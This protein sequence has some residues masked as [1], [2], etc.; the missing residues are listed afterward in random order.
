MAAECGDLASH[1]R[2]SRASHGEGRSIQGGNTLHGECG[3]SWKA[4]PAPGY[5]AVGVYR[6]GSFHRLMT[7][8]SIPTISGE[9]WG[10]LEKGRDFQELGCTS[11][12]FF[13]FFMVLSQ[14]CHS[15]GGCVI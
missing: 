1:R 7:G 14:N 3:P 6:G 8:R 10:F 4:S 9:G 5:G 12:F 11:L 2:D 15:S 13:F